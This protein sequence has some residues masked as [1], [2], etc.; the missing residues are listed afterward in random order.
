ML[1]YQSR[2][3]GY[4]AHESPVLSSF[5]AH[6]EPFAD[7]CM[8]AC[9]LPEAF[10]PFAAM[11]NETRSAAKDFGTLIKARK[12][13]VISLAQG[14]IKVPL[15]PTELHRTSGVQMV[16]T[17][18]VCTTPTPSRFITRSDLKSEPR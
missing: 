11:G 8:T 13:P 5:N 1:D 10:G 12:S 16:P 15:G 6:W 14:D 9:V 17:G 4:E 2:T 7:R 18:S 3:K